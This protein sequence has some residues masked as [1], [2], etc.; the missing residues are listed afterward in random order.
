M[1]S[2]QNLG[3]FAMN[4]S[5]VNSQ[6]TSGVPTKGRMIWNAARG[7][8]GAIERGFTTAFTGKLQTCTAKIEASVNRKQS[9]KT[10]PDSWPFF[11]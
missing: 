4:T 5:N 9:A 1:Y 2:W 6:G 3:G 10:E 8:L 11:I 7:A